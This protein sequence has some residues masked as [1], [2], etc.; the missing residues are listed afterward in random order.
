MLKPYVRGITMEFKA[1]RK[2]APAIE[3]PGD[4]DNETS[5]FSGSS[6]S[7]EIGLIGSASLILRKPRSGCLEGRGWPWSNLSFESLRMRF[8]GNRDDERIIRISYHSPSNTGGRFS[9]KALTPST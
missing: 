4:W 9:W 7:Y 3:G 2:A 6:V 5:R 1:G 8:D